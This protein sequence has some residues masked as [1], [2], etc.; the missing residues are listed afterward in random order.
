MMQQQVMPLDVGVSHSPFLPNQ[1]PMLTMS[2]A[3]G[4]V[5]STL[6]CQSL[7]A[8][9]VPWTKFFLGSLVLSVTNILFLVIT[10]RPT[11]NDIDR[12]GAPDHDP[13]G[14]P[15][16]LFQNDTNSHTHTIICSP[17]YGFVVRP[18]LGDYYIHSLVLW[19]VSHYW[20]LLH[21]SADFIT[22]ISETPTQ[23]FVSTFYTCRCSTLQ[24]IGRL[25][26]IYWISG[27][28]ELGSY[29]HCPTDVF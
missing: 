25:Y 3:L 2:T 10:F 13:K 1:E 14:G 27:S 8:L 29:W 4:G 19:M 16:I 28:V 26:H 9:N 7:L 11:N 15:S 24:L 18:S 22:D 6:L 21:K 12:E 5:V 17:N 20:D 23:G